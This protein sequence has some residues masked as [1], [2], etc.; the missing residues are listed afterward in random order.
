MLM[1]V[2][3]SVS[4]AYECQFVV[5]NVTCDIMNI[6]CQRL[7]L[8]MAINIV[9]GKTALVFSNK[10]HWRTVWGVVCSLD[11]LEH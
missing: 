8:H 2:N 11:D 3:L 5:R 1:S 10:C 6:E 4:H 9:A 7:C